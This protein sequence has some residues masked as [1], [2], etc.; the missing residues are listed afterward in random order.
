[1]KILA[2][3]DIHGN[4][5]AVKRLVGE[6]SEVDAVLIAGDITH[7]GNG[8]DAEEI[9]KPLFGLGV[10]ILAVMGNCDGRDVLDVLEKLGISVHKRRR[11]IEGLGVVGFG[12]S[13]IT[14]FSTIWEFSDDEIYHS[15]KDNYREGDIVLTHAPPYG[16]SLDRTYSGVHAGSK[17]LRRFIEEYQPPFCICGHIH[18]ARG[19]ETLGTTIAVNPGPLSRGFYA[20]ID[21]EDREVFKLKLKS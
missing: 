13:N 7:F 4:Y 20:V 14:P 10:P 3:T 12:G 16:T 1:M 9:L 11:E 21:T 6:I 17:G 15:L 8:R 2:I 18:E 19:I 5:K